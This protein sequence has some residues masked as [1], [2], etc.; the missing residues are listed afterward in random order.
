[1]ITKDIDPVD[2]AQD[3]L[4]KGS[5]IQDIEYALANYWDMGFGEIADV[6]SDLSL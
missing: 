1:M 5:S 4:N 2:Y 6:L 3:E